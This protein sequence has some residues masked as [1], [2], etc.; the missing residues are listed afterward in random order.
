MSEKFIEL[1]IPC[2][3]CLVA[4]ACKDKK[5][6]GTYKNAEL[7]DIFLGLKKWNEKEKVFKKG[8]IEAWVNMGCDIFSN[9]RPNEV[10]DIPDSAFPEYLNVLIELVNILQWLINSKSWRDGKPHDFDKSELK[11]KLKQAMGWV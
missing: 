8:V 10:E 5:K 9:M 7:R 2:K 4:P 1:Y 6:I 11:N 3:E